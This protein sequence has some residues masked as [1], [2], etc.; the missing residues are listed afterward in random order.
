MRAG[1]G[2]NTRVAT[3][4]TI[5]PDTRLV[6]AAGVTV[7]LLG[8]RTIAESRAGRTEL[9]PHG[10]AVLDAF[11]WPATIAEALEALAPRVGDAAG[12]TVLLRDIAALVEAGALVD[13]AARAVA[14][15][16]GA[17]AYDGPAMHVTMLDDRRRT[18]AF[19]E[20]IRRQV[21]SGDVVVDLGSGSGVLAAFS[22]Q[23]GA[24][25]VWAC[26]RTPMADVARTLLAD[27]GLNDVVTVHE[28]DSSALTIP[29]PADVLVSEMLGDDP[30]EEQLLA[31][32]IDARRRLLKPDARLIP[33]GVAVEVLPVQVPR[34]ERDATRLTPARLRR[35]EAD[36]ELAFD[37][38]SGMN[39][40]TPRRVKRRA[41]DVRDWP[42]LGAA[43]RVADVDLAS[44]TSRVV[45]GH[46]TLEIARRGTLSGLFLYFVADLGAGVTLSQHPDEAA[47][48]DHWP[49]LLFV[50]PEPRTATTRRVR[51][52][53]SRTPDRAGHAST[54]RH[55]G[56]PAPRAAALRHPGTTAPGG[57]MLNQWEN[58]T[59]KTL[60]AGA[61]NRSPKSRPKRKS[62]DS[63]SS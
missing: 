25:R 50:L 46:A 48:T 1:S 29:E 9:G 28:C 15:S 35:W 38:L 36:Y 22:A 61:E 2:H 6:V 34:A 14:W 33:A 56:T 23:A 41:V 62:P 17:R 13:E 19:R 11:R 55:L 27:N 59:R 44:V 57:Y 24:R 43:S 7:R 12:G 31:M 49:Q 37:V 47:A 20:A 58:L 30:F 32:T 51:R 53:R 5:A 52:S 21:R 4:P 45:D 60:C 63:P 3:P 39:A 42:R 16:A 18:R 40:A 54:A 26:E 8:A 10:L